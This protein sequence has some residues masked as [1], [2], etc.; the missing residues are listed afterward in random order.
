MDRDAQVLS[1][2]DRPAGN[3]DPCVWPVIKIPPA[4]QVP[5]YLR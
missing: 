5:V 4:F 2:N 1:L 3:A